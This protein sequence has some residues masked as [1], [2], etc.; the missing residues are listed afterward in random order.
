MNAKKIIYWVSTV[1]TCGMMTAVA[2]AYLVRE[3]KMIAGFESLGYPAYFPDIL[4]VA[5]LLGVVALLIPGF[6]VLKEWAYA[7]FVFTFTG[8]LISHLAMGQNHEAM[9]PVISLV[10]LAISYWTRPAN[11][12][13]N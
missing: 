10:L 6:K 13:L 9:L 8:A 5:K 2:V 11:R 3:P 4:G 1:L 12:Q 7:G